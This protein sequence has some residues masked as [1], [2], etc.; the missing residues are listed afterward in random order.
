MRGGVPLPARRATREA[1]IAAADEVGIRITLLDACYVAGGFGEPVS[2]AQK[3][4]SDG[5]AARWAERVSGLREA[6]HARRARRSTPSAPCPPTSSRPSSSGSGSGRCTSTLRAARRER[7]LPRRARLHA[8]RSCWPST[9]RSARTRRRP[10]HPPHRGTIASCSRRRRSACARRPSATSPTAS[11]DAGPTPLASAPTATRS[12]TSSRRRARSSS[13][14]RLATERPRPLRARPS[15]CAARPTTRCL[16]WP[17]AGRIEPGALADLVTVCARLRP[18]AGD[19]RA[20]D[21]ARVARLRRHRRRRPQ[22]DR[23][24]PA[25]R[26]DGAHTSIDV[27]SE[28]SATIKGRSGPGPL[29]NVY[30]DRQH[31]DAGHERPRT[32]D[33]QR[34]RAGFRGRGRAVGGPKGRLSPRGRGRSGSTPPGRAVI[35]GFVDSPRAPGVRRGAGGGVR[36][37]DGRDGVQ[38]RR[39]PARPSNATREASDEQLGGNVDRL[40]SEALRSGTTTVETKSGYGL[41]VPDERRSLQVA[42]PRTQETTFL[43]AHVVAPEYEDD[44]DA[45]VD[46]VKGEMLDACA[47]HARWIDVFCEKGAF[48]GDQTRA[49]LAGR[50]RQGPDAAGPRQP[51]RPRPGRA[52]RGRAQ[53][54]L[55]R[56][57]HPRHRRRRRRAREQRHRR[58]AAPGRRVQHPRAVPRRAPADRRRRHRRARRRLQPGLEL[59]DEHPV[60]HRDRRARDGHDPRRGGLGRDGRAARWRSA[61]ATSA[62]SRPG[63]RADA[64]LLEAPSHIH[65]AY[66]PGVPLV[67]AVWRGG[68][69]AI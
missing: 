11:A 59:H 6:P 61:A 32:R 68:T 63:A 1:L 24:R 29:G 53:R 35:P 39:Y 31:R 62:T 38:R 23:L 57:R 45:Y 51:A 42:T 8:D 10:R 15:S 16:G 2:G 4:F 50:D 13:T 37:A 66:R 36:R 30:V 12:S 22:R 7:G 21:D 40:I 69:R 34:C 58:H 55:R 43:G 56:P 25:D 3:R 44:P 52:A 20:R 9:A 48:D 19:G 41:T 64:V 28:L 65:L 46:L 27:P 60:L 49:I 67:A 14:P 47:P 5:D 17:D 18:P 26:Q 33:D 54:G